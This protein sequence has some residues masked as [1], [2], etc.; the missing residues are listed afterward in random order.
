[1]VKQLKSGE[2]IIAVTFN[3]HR[4]FQCSGLN[5][6]RVFY[7]IQRSFKA[8]AGEARNHD[9]LSAKSSCKFGQQF[10]LQAEDEIF[11]DLAFDT[12]IKI[13]EQRESFYKFHFEGDE[14]RVTPIRLKGLD[15]MKVRQ[16][17]PSPYFGMN[18]NWQV[19][20]MDGEGVVSLQ[21]VEL[22]EGEF[23]EGLSLSPFAPTIKLI[24]LYGAQ[25]L[26]SLGQCQTPEL[27]SE[28]FLVGL[29]NP[30]GGKA[31]TIWLKHYK[32]GILTIDENDDDSDGPKET[33]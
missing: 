31:P 15:F 1:M 23:N 29:R 28:L 33:I 19:A 12:W 8:T 27:Q 3:D 13:D 7:D 16:I 10:G 5:G 26:K 32:G 9:I 17:V 6:Y 11:T 22:I 25:N 4:Y 2:Q 30:G 14:E 18:D 20:V 24:E 21:T